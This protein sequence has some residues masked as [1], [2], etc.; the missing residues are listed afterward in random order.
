M[1]RKL[2]NELRFGMGYAELNFNSNVNSL[3][4]HLENIA[5]IYI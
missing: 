3:L 2:V 1:P 5:K 4:R